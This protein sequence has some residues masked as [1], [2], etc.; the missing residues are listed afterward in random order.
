MGMKVIRDKTPTASGPV[1]SPD[2]RANAAVIKLLSDHLG[3]PKS[4]LVIVRGLSSRLKTVQ[5]L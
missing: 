4:R 5:V 2:G 1:F 3:V